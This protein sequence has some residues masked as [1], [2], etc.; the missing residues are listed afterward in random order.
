[1][2][3]LSRLFVFVAMLENH[4]LYPVSDIFVPSLKFGTGLLPRCHHMVVFVC[5]IAIC[6]WFNAKF[7]FEL[8]VT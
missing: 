2:A 4:Y 5:L 3:L 1:M 7:S 8:S 6:S